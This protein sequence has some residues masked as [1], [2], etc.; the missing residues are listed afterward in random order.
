[1]EGKCQPRREEF[2]EKL[3]TMERRKQGG[4]KDE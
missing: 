3:Y 2:R 4:E 1:M